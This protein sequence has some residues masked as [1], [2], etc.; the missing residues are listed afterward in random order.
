VFPVELITD[1]TVAC[2]LRT[3][4]DCR[5]PERDPRRAVAVIESSSA[6]PHVDPGSSPG[7]VM[8]DLW[9]T[10]WYW[11]SSSQSASV[12]PT[13]FH[14]IDCP[15]IISPVAGAIGQT[16]AEVP[17]GLSLMPPQRNVRKH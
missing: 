3:G 1:C 14:F 7:Q 16:A 5:R 12:S 13:N 6:S 15:H 17:S 2:C 4:G 9:W 8:W 11:V 10:D